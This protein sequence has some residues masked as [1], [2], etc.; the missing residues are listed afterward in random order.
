MLIIP[1]VLVAVALYAWV[2]TLPRE[3]RQRGGRTPTHHL[4]II[5]CRN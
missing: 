5:P 2:R 3:S 1:E 4:N